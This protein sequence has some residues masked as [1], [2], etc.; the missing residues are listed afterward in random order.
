MSPQDELL[1]ADYTEHNILSPAAA[2]LIAK[3]SAT[4]ERRSEESQ[5][6]QRSPRFTQND[7][8]IAGGTFKIHFTDDNTKSNL[9]DDR[10]KT[11]ARQNPAFQLD[12]EFS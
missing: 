10:S 12:D 1:G 7:D 2:E 4:A 3:S 5:I 6:S 11:P 9:N 8:K